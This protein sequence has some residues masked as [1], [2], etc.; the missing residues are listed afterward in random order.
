MV[1]LIAICAVMILAATLA[2]ALNGAIC[3]TSAECLN[4]ARL[5]NVRDG[6][7]PL[8]GWRWGGAARCPCRTMAGPR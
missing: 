8:S 7:G 1:R 2:L 5:V 6:I 4:D 3:H